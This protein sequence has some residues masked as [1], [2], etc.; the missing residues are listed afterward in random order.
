MTS[1]RGSAPASSEAAL[2]RL[3]I[4]EREALPILR[5][6][7]QPAGPPHYLSQ[8][9]RAG[10]GGQP[11]HPVRR[12]PPADSPERVLIALLVIFCAAFYII[13]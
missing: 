7:L 1:G 5:Y 11:H 8:S 3:K 10:R 6:P 4:L 2:L 13:G 9:R 12:L